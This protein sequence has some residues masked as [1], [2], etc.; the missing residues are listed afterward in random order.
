MNLSSTF[1]TVVVPTR[2]RP[3]ALASCLGRLR[4]GTVPVEI[5]VVDDG[6]ADAMGVE[7]IATAAAA[8]LVRSAGEGPAAARNAGALRAGGRTVLFLDDDCLPAP[9][10]VELMCAAVAR[11]PS[12]IVAG[13][14]L[15]PADASAGVLASQVVI[16]H[17]MSEGLEPVSRALR[18][19]PSCN[20]AC[21]REAI[22]LLP[23]DEGFSIAGGEDREWSE[24]ARAARMEPRFAP[25]AVVV[26]RMAPGAGEFVA[27]QYRYGR[28][29]ALLLA[30]GARPTTA[31][32]GS[33]WRLIRRGLEIG[34][35]VGALVAL[36]QAIT[37]AGFLRE[38]LRT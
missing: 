38:R 28:G 18:F 8:T 34:P 15:A 4:A 21:S 33:R 27:R 7:S 23:F 6:S 1:A 22:G 12:G 11:S 31:I 13:R 16:D 32:R 36:A 14:T 19:A 9:D 24:R 17:L 25:D 37:L 3:C 29:A 2:D 10:W 30:V 26:H 35:R 20:L 5:I